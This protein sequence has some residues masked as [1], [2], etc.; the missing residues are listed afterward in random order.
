MKRI[1]AGVCVFVLVSVCLVVSPGPVS[2]AAIPRSLPVTQAPQSPPEPEVVTRHKKELLDADLVRTALTPSDH[3]DVQINADGSITVEAVDLKQAQAEAEKLSKKLGRTIAVR[4]VD[5]DSP[6]TEKINDFVASTIRLNFPGVDSTV[7]IGLDEQSPYV[8]VTM[9]D[10]SSLRQAE[11]VVRRELKAA[12]LSSRSRASR[13]IVRFTAVEQ[14]KYS[15]NRSAHPVRAGKFISHGCTLGYVMR[16]PG[17]WAAVTAGHC[18]GGLAEYGRVNFM[19]AQGQ[20]TGTMIVR[21]AGNNW[22]NFPVNPW[23]YRDVG[24]MWIGLP[25]DPVPT[26]DGVAAVDTGSETRFIYGVT[27]L[28]NMSGI[29]LCH[30]GF[31]MSPYAYEQCG[32]VTNRY[33]Q[34]TIGGVTTTNNVCVSFGTYAGDSGGPVYW[35][36]PGSRYVEASGIISYMWGTTQASFTQPFANKGCFVPQRDVEYVSGWTTN[37]N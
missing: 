9:L 28:V 7:G 16:R 24:G 1:A 31:G 11:A 10:K 6:T 12:G 18:Y 17:G 33:V 25:D 32:T 29:R 15:G 2:S 21:S 8:E 34:A 37:S 5:V 36:Y 4:Q 23:T 26:Y 27:E 13:E 14:L 19:S 3:G 22:Y 35:S 20:D 30:T